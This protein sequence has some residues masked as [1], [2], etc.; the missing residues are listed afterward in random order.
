MSNDSL[1]VSF[2]DLSLEV[3]AGSLRAEVHEHNAGE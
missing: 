2:Y 1:I 3:H